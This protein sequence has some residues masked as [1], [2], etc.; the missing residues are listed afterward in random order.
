LEYR[1]EYRL[2]GRTGVQV[3]QLCLGT[4]AFGG[5]ADEA[6][7]GRMFDA[8]LAAGINFVDTA[9]M[10]SGGKSEEV[11]GRLLRGRRDELVIATKCF[12]ATAKD[13]NSR[14]GSRRHIMRV[15]E[16]SLKRLQTDRIDIFYLHKHDA[17]TPIEESLRALEDL[18]REGKILYPGV[19]NY[20]AWQAQLAL[21]AQE[22]NGW[23]RLQITQPMY[24]LVKRQAEAEI[25]PMAQANGISVCPYSPAGGGLLSGKYV[26]RQAE[27]G[28]LSVNKMYTV[29]YGEEW[30]HDTATQFAAL[31]K[32]AGYHPMSLAVAWVA[33]HPGVTAPIV[34]ARS[35]AQLQASLDSVKVKMTPELRARISALSRTPPPATDRLE[36]AK[37]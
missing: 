25:L 32:E 2:L 13:V 8:A 27:G 28:R 34:G 12:D 24:N 14:G 21:S 15:A 10:Y 23:G 33:A 26:N 1:V 31:A 22:R 5:D 20:A 4:M 3:S 7:S 36:E 29:R 35:L 30:M 19:S 37:A 9:N 17:L 11:L 6:E 16:T 18:A